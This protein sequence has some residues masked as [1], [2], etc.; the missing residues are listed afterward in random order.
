MSDEKP[1]GSAGG[2]ARSAALSDDRK[3]EIAQKGALARWG[4]KATHKGN[5]KEEFDFDVECY[6]LDDA[7]KTAV[8]SQSGMGDALGLISTSADRLHRLLGG[9]NIAPYVNR[10]LREKVS[11]PLVFQGLASIANIPPPVVKGYDVTILIDVCKAVIQAESEGTLLK[12]QLNVARQAHIILNASAKAGIKGLV[13][14]L[15]GYDATRQEVIQAFKLFVQQ[16]AREYEREFPPQLYGE[17]YRLYELPTPERGRPWK[18][19]HLT[20]DHVYHPL[21][22]SNGKVLKLTREQKAT[23]GSSGNKLHQFL[24]EIGVKTLRTHLG[25]VLGIARIS[26]TQQEYEQHINTLFGVQP[27]LPGINK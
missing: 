18:A 20:I 1:T 17:W 23:T 14:A 26:K 19:K 13:Y 22:R 8:I 24:S 25:Q 6:V 16:E 12:R 27:D 5:F 15:A 3:R 11:K 7:Q 2:A 21:A 9:R 4:A 10:E